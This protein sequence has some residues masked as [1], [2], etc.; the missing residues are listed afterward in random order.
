VNRT[1]T[2]RLESKRDNQVRSR[3]KL[4]LTFGA[5]KH[6]MKHRK[7]YVCKYPWCKRAADGF[8]TT[9]DRDRHVKSVH[10]EGLERWWKCDY[11]DCSKTNKEHYFDR[12][13]NFKAH[14]KRRHGEVDETELDDLVER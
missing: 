5:R 9:N 8:A 11:P 4:I 1:E 6:I 3:E 7:I 14:V 2:S 12:K 10:K 13:D